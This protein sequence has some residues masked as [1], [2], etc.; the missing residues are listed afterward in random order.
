MYVPKVPA[1]AA[2]IALVIA[3]FGSIPFAAAASDLAAAASSP[4]TKC[5]SQRGQDFLDAGRYDH[6]TREFTCVIEA[7]PTAIEGYRGRIEAELLLGR[8]SD[9][10]RDY[11]RVTAVVEPVHPDAHEIIRAGYADRLA[12]APHDIPALTGASFERWANF[13]YAQAIH[14]LDRLLDVRPDD[15][16]GTLFV[17]SSRLLQGGPGPKER[18]AADLERAIALA[19]ESPD[20]RFIVADAYTYGLPD[21]ERAF[22][23]ATLAL[24]WGLGTPRVHAILATAYNAFGDLLAGG[25]HIQTHI[26]L[27]TTELVTAPPLATGDSLALDLVP[28]RTY[29]V[30]VSATAGE[31][32]S[33]STSSPDFWDSIAVLLAPDGSPAVGSDDE[34]AYFA[35]FDWVAPETGTYLLQ[36]TSF[37]SINTGELVVTRA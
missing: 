11:A 18:G 19:P 22:A 30:P 35:A 25:T 7:Q 33:I 34:N 23:E 31:T 16:Y 12:V 26:D 24:N 2:A 28:G 3:A 14:L 13:D 4:S 5:T 29:A 1:F 15:P 10:L 9:A 37:E 8:Y 27:V 20:V 21:L 6:A 36:V 32:I 17:G